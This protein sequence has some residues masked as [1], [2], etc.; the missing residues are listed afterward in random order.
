ML[1]TTET[2]DTSRDRFIDPS[3]AILFAAPLAVVLA[4][5]PKALTAIA[6]CLTVLLA[7]ET[8]SWLFDRS[9]KK[10][11]DAMSLEQLFVAS[12][13]E[14][15]PIDYSFDAPAAEEVDSTENDARIEAIVAAASAK[16]SELGAQYRARV[17][18]DFMSQGG[19][20]N[21]SPPQGCPAALN[22]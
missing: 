18:A 14:L 5:N 10:R 1:K 4:D 7:L 22:A 17:I 16:A 15:N 11:A 19:T 2:I 9:A 8:L 21:G 6:L 20:P 13:V 12:G 3:T